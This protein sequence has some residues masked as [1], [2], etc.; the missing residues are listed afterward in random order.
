MEVYIGRRVERIL[1]AQ[2][3]VVATARRQGRAEN[4]EHVQ[5]VEGAEIDAGLRETG[6]RAWSSWLRDEWQPLSRAGGSR[7][8]QPQL[9]SARA[10]AIL[11]R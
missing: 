1:L 2:P 10:R 4:D 8:R 3:E 7:G 11:N 6:V 5:G 9:P